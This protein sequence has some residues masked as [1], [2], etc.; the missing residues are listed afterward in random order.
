MDVDQGRFAR[1]KQ[2]RAHAEKT[3]ALVQL[4]RRNIRRGHKQHLTRPRER[5]AEMRLC[6][7]GN[8]KRRDRAFAPLQ[9]LLHALVVRRGIE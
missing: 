2:L 5:C 6:V 4:R 9:R 1:Q 3:R 7:C 8:A